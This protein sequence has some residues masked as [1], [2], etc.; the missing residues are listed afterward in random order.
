MKEIEEKLVGKIVTISE[1]AGYLGMKVSE[2][3]K[4]K[5]CKKI[6]D[7]LLHENIII[8]PNAVYFKKNYKKNDCVLLSKTKKAS[9]LNTNNYELAATL[10]DLG[11]DLVYS[12]DDFSDEEA[13]KI[14][15]TVGSD[16]LNTPLEFEHLKLRIELYKTQKPNIS[17]VI[18][19]ISKNLETKNLETLSEYLVKLAL[20]DKKHFTN[21]EDKKIK[22]FLSKLGV[23]E[24]YIEKIY[25]QFGINEILKNVELKTSQNNIQQGSLIPKNNEVVLDRTEFILDQEKLHQIK[26]D[27]ETVKLILSEIITEE[28]ENDDIPIVRE[29][30]E[31]E[32]ELDNKYLPFLNIITQQNKWDKK[33]L[34]DKAKEHK[35]MVNAAISKINEW[36]E[37][38]YG[39]YLLFENDNN[40]EVN[41]LI[42]ENIK[43]DNNQAS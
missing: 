14:Y 10:V 36:A 5:E 28:E 20:N 30:K 17:G 27:T 37:E 22:R 39:D 1:I 11:V 3:L 32:S 16:F 42:L 8:E 9:M 18:N 43:N 41:T 29:V 7:T 21:E 15:F 2:K 25:K 23:T 24:F 40:F 35:F 31:N 34:R 6:V 4:N 19:N 12:D 33:S 26:S 13:R 38:K